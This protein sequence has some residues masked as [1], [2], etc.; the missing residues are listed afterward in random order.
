MQSGWNVE[1]LRLAAC[2]WNNLAL[3]PAEP[4]PEHTN[5]SIAGSV[6][7]ARRETSERA[8]E[9]WL[10]WRTAA[11]LR[12]AAEED[13]DEALWTS[14]PRARAADAMAAERAHQVL[15]ELPA[16]G[17]AGWRRRRGVSRTRREPGSGGISGGRL[18]SLHA[19]F[20]QPLDRPCPGW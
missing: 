16:S 11:L 19:L 18:G 14:A 17:G 6:E 13:S 1:I 8:S 15:D 9:D 4:L 3:P 10:P 5:A 12:A 20:P 2:L 7:T